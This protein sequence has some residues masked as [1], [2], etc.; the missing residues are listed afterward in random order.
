MCCYKSFLNGCFYDT[1]IS[2]GNV[3]TH[4]RGVGIFSDDVIINFRLIL[5]VEID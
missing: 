3:A 2:Q 5:T 4:L 1:D